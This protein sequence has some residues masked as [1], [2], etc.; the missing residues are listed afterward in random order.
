VIELLLLAIGLAADAFAV[1]IASGVAARGERPPAFRI[2]FAFGLAQ[3]LMPLLGVLLAR[4]AGIWFTNV[5]HWLAFGLL[6]FLGVRMI[7]AGVD[8]ADAEASFNTGTF[9]GLLIAAAATSVDAAAAGITLPLLVTPI[10]MSCLVIGGITALLS[11]TGAAV[12][13]H[14]GLKFG[15]RA[16]IVGGLVLIGIGVRILISHLAM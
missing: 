15:T 14:L 11:Y 16:E 8:G 6:S 5:D 1:S 12:G 10:W 3:G 2:A 7:K 13:G 9:V 4:V